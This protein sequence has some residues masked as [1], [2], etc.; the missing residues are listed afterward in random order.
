MESYNCAYS[1]EFYE[2]L[3][4]DYDY[5]LDEVTVDVYEDMDY[6]VEAFCGYSELARVSPFIIGFTGI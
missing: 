4:H 6:V 1:P 3:Y 5:L 2:E